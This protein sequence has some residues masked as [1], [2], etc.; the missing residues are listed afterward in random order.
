VTGKI[1]S[2]EDLD[3]WKLGFELAQQVY[4]ITTSFPAQERYN[5]CSQL[6]RASSSIPANIAEGYGRHTPKD[7]LQFLV[8]ARGSL[9]ETQSHLRLAQAVGLMKSEDSEKLLASC[10]RTRQ[11]LQG[12]IRHVR[13]KI[14]G[15]DGKKQST[16]VSN[17]L[18]I[19]TALD[20]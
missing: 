17:H 20:E 12:L 4:A 3:A 10:L 11:A 16:S 15:F 18:L 9:A 14:G 13:S 5:L 7:Y 2:F 1:T 19:E 8:C 6:R